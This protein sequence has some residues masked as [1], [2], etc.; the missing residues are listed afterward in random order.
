MKA[1]GFLCDEDFT[2]RSR[3]NRC[4][5]KALE[6]HC[7]N[8][9]LT[10]YGCDES[11]AKMDNAESDDYVCMMRV[12][13]IVKAL[14]IAIA[15]IGLYQLLSVD[16]LCD[17]EEVQIEDD[18]SDNFEESHDGSLKSEQSVTM[19]ATKHTETHASAKA[20]TTKTNSARKATTA[21]KL[22]VE[23]LIDYHR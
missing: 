3:R 17:V 13:Y 10:S 16:E 11:L 15:A 5:N 23:K 7:I 22:R 21:E 12:F 18:T 6:V 1:D 2:R 4:D 14:Q 8:S 20:I 19:R 9:L